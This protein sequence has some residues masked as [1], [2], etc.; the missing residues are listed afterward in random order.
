MRTKA[1]ETMEKQKRWQLF[2]IISVLVLTVY[3]ILPT[4]FYYIKPLEQPVNKSTAITIA[5]EAST[6]VNKLA[7]ESKNWTLSFAKLLGISKVKVSIA[8]N[9]PKHINILFNDSADAQL[10][11]KHLPRAGSLIPFFPSQLSLA[12]IDETDDGKG[13]KLSRNISINLNNSDFSNYFQFS[14]KFD[15][16][17]K[18]TEFYQKILI[19]RLVQLGI[20]TAGVTE[21]AQ[22]LSEALHQNN[23]GQSDELIM[24]ISQNMSDYL[25]T[26]G[27]QSKISKRALESIFQGNFQNKKKSLEAFLSLTEGVKDRVRIKK[28]ELQESIKN[29]TDII[30]KQEAE[31]KLSIL[32]SKENLL[33][34]VLSFCK[35]QSSVDFYPEHPLSF[36]ELLSK[37]ETID[38][39]I[40][41]SIGNHHPL[42]ENLIIDIENQ[43]LSI[44]FHKDV[45]KFKEN[46]G[47]EKSKAFLKEQFEQILF[48]EIARISR[49]SAEEIK[50]YKG[51]FAVALSN[52]E[53]SKSF[54]AFDLSYV[55]KDQISQIIN[56]IKENWNP[57]HPD[58]IRENFPISDFDSYEKLNSNE[59]KLGL[60]VFSPVITNQAPP[61]GM[62]SSSIYVVAKGLNQILKKYESDPHSESAQEFIRDISQLRDILKNYGFL[63]YSGNT[64]PLSGMFSKDFIFEA[65]EFYAPLIQATREDF[66]VH[67]TKRFAVLDFTNIKQR[68][69]ASNQIDNKIHEDLLKWRDE[70]QS[71]QVNPN[72]NA[73]LDVPKPTQSPFLSNLL[74]SVKKYFRG[75][76]RKILH[77]GLDLSGGKTVQIE[78][79]DNNNRK[80]T[81]PADLTQ[82]VNELYSRV[83]KMGVSEVSIR[84]EGTNITLD[85]P[86]AQGLSA[87][88]LVKASSMYFHIVN[89][90]FSL[91]NN[92]L[93]EYVNKF[94]Q[95]I[96]NEAVVT[97]KK[98]V[99]N[100]NRIAWK[101][102]YGESLNPETVSPRTEAAKILLK[103]GLKL[104][105]ND[106]QTTSSLFDKEFSKIAIIR[107]KSFSDWFGQTH[108][109]MIVFNN[110]ALE[111]SSLVNV[112][113][114]Y[115]QTKGNY[116]S[117]EVKGS[118]TNRDGSKISPRDGLYSWT[119]N[120]SKEKVLGT[121]EEKYTQGK[122]WRMAVILNGSIISAPN[123][124]SAIKDSAMITGSFTQREVNK[125]E[126]DLKAGSL[127]FSP[128][129]LSE[130]NVS[131]EL[132]IKERLQ[133]ITATIVALVVVIAAVTAY[134]KFAGIVASTALLINLLIMWATLQNIQATMTL[135]GIA[136]VILSIGM[137]VD[138]NVLVFERVKEEFKNSGRIASA[139]NAGYKKAFTAILDSNLTTIIAALI[140]LHFDS[141][142]IKGFA[143]TII[144][145]IISSMFTALFMTKFFFAGW[146]EN[147]KNKSLK[148]SHWIDG[149]RLNFLKHGKLAVII[150]AILVIVGGIAGYGSKQTIF[151]MDFTGGYSISLE[152][153]PEKNTNYREAVEEALKSQ[154]LSARD[155][156]VRE[157][158]PSNNI[159]VFLTRNLDGLGKPFYMLPVETDYDVMY[160]YQNNPRILWIVA[161]LE[162]KGLKLTETSL[163]HLSQQWTSVSGQ[164]SDT[165]KSN[166]L[167]GL[168]LALVCILIYIT[169]RFEFKYAVAATLGLAHDVFITL[170]T[171]CVLHKL[172]VPIQ[173]ELNTIAALMAIIG[174]SLNDTIIIFDRI[175]EDLK[176]NRKLSFK[177]V[178]NQALNTTLSRTLMTSGTTILVLLALVILGGSTIFGFALVMTIG[179]LYGTLS[180][181]FIAAPLLYFLDKRE[182]VKDKVLINHH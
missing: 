87:A 17:K 67:G 123:L 32:V 35:K 22:L 120:F 139:L 11:K 52:L 18:P 162:S 108:P 76:E 48:N 126:A 28:I 86:G 92:D 138:A 44:T 25:K 159:R 38:G 121:G 42:I 8:E 91:G 179:I 40:S 53:D 148:M 65:Q 29:L 10:F 180:S 12:S 143:L 77:W 182:S 104:P 117:F 70:Y 39:Q 24:V 175:R 64:Y 68:I 109:L 26:F 113:A 137:S 122:G 96:W 66:N 111:G 60:L 154:G 146:A 5:H 54:L 124:D 161:A 7:E 167:Y 43:I 19:D 49:E 20:A 144:I 112:H 135:A 57:T 30:L 1:I 51:T 156:Q 178:C 101:H 174:Y 93:S 55:A 150:S 27:E 95:D 131:P 3:N 21:N 141:G 63:G 46:L 170:G 85:F 90:K 168:S 84:Q 4:V 59:K 164:I 118:Q 132:G 163:D 140:L 98:D 136:G 142:P 116:L 166:A 125:L 172:G 74:L 78:L 128:Y 176:T 177:E 106:D 151:G 158:S 6:R 9:D 45:M 97:N 153:S 99:D 149:T 2:L 114:G 71:A 134:Y 155:F 80:V 37:I 160:S 119:S 58:L 133:G 171:V 73:R 14:E 145:G 157:L 129:I 41:L 110:Y 102:L 83:N 23:Q 100:I 181:L 173:I 130:K 107:G 103:E 165:M 34:A 15:Q 33:T 115:D 62:K 13:L 82:G 47:Y 75:D 89:E 69:L 127:S 152:I 36:Q 169:F 50:P 105:L 88:E 16:N 81:N 79:R 61:Q 31:E 72:L 147:P 56:S 94:L